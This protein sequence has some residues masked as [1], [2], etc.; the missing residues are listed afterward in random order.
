MLGRRSRSL[1]FTLAAAFALSACS[2]SE[3]RSPGA[4]SSPGGSAGGSP[5]TSPSGPPAS[6]EP[7]KAEGDLFVFGVAYDTGDDIAKGRIDE[8]KDQYPEVNLSFS[9][10]GFDDQPFL[11]ALESGDPPDVARIERRRIGTYI[12]R[13]VLAPID[14]CVAKTGADMSVFYDAAMTPLTWEG[15]VYGFPEDF[16]TRVW[17]LNNPAFEEA[18][19]D[20][21][22][23]DASNWDAIKQA[24]TAL[25]KKDGNT[26]SRIGID[27]K[28][29]EFLPLWAKANGVDIL[30]EDGLEANL[31][32]PKVVEAVE[33]GLSLIQEHGGFPPFKSFRDTW[34]FF[35][36]NNQVARNQIG[37]W[38]QEQ[39]YLNTLTQSP[40][41]DIT[42]KPF[43]TRDGQEITY[44]DGT[45]LTIVKD[46]DNFD[47]ACAYVYTLTSQAAWVRA[48]TERAAA[49]KEANSAEHG[50]VHRQPA[51]ERGDL[52]LDRRPD[53]R[54]DLQSR[55][56]D[57]P[58]RPRQG[59]RPAGLA[60]RHGVHR[61]DGG[62]R[63]CRA[64]RRER[65][66]GA[67]PGEPGCAGRDRRRVALGALTR[68]RREDG[69]D[70]RSR[71]AAA[72]E[73]AKPATSGDA[74]GAVLHRAVGHRVPSPDA[75]ADALEP[76]FSFTDYDPL[77]DST[78]FLGLQNYADMVD[79]RRVHTSMWNT[80]VMTILY[81]PGSMVLGLLLAVL[82]DSGR[83][84]PRAS[85]GPR[86]TCPNV[87][88]AVAVG[89]IFLLLLNGQEGIVN[90]GLRAIRLP[91]PFWLEDGPWIK[92]GLLLMLLWSIGGTV[93]IYFAALRNVPAEQYEA[94]RLDGANTWQQ[95]LHITVPFISGALFFT[96]IINTIASLQL[97]TEVYTMFFGQQ[98][99]QSPAAQ[100]E[101]LFYVVYLFDQAFTRFNMGYASAMAWVLFVVIMIITFV[102]IRLSRRF[103]YYEGE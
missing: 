62:R 38:P 74:L 58:R 14:D 47:A 94:A 3:S 34:A 6:V 24:N 7:L 35:E 33:F 81:V 43:L 36:A 75:G 64:E 90:Q 102:Q 1:T 69:Y 11:A 22:A 68:S 91:A 78:E 31:D 41:V 42:V 2:G 16:N 71:A 18:N 53:R 40:D 79:D 60:R 98:S 32:D 65:G 84:R 66:G 45:A 96:L 80:V 8:F 17:L 99:G 21:N 63:E 76:V 57:G 86:S 56:R 97:F 13:D 85:S 67:G 30:S 54:A 82:L 9:E 49:R 44:A 46:T 92:P 26:L 87:T 51:R 39:W 93:V 61:G 103:V 15:K 4:P 5:A 70:R 10:S 29:P 89:A 28:L 59:I 20:P 23:F 48:A 50:D 19:V 52:Q 101:A 83:T 37:G 100:R 72:A 12:A 95:F 25:L 55:R 77:R 88:P 27:P 73:P